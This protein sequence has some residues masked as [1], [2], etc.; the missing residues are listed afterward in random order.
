[1]MSSNE[2][3][4]F[5]SIPNQESDRPLSTYDNLNNGD[6]KTNGSTTA[7][8]PTSENE[9]IERCENANEFPF[10]G[11]SFRFD[12]LK[13]LQQQ[14][15]QQQP[16]TAPIIHTSNGY[17]NVTNNNYKLH[18]SSNGN[19][20][21]NTNNNHHNHTHNDSTHFNGNGVNQMRNSQGHNIVTTIAQNHSS[22]APLSPSPTSSASSSNS[23]S[24]PASS[25]SSTS[26]SLSENNYKQS[27]LQYSNL[28]ENPI[29]N[30]SFSKPV[31]SPAKSQFL[32]LHKP[33]NE[34][35]YATETDG[36]V[37]NGGGGAIKKQ[38]SEKNAL[39]EVD[40][41]SDEEP[42][43]N[44]YGNN[45]IRVMANGSSTT[46]QYQN[47]PSNSSCYGQNQIDNANECTCTCKSSDSAN[48]IQQYESDRYKCNG[49]LTTQLQQQQQQR[50]LANAPISIIPIATMNVP[51]CSKTVDLSSCTTSMKPAKS[52][53][54]DTSPSF[55]M[56]Q[57]SLSQVKTTFIICCSVL[58]ELINCFCWFACFR[59]ENSYVELICLIRWVNCNWSFDTFS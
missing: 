15:Q 59:S 30:R 12:E 43:L 36:K 16:N 20:N 44:N 58:V 38:N 41:I 29:A 14:Q 42:L 10:T 11:I 9:C 24:S 55:R 47:V 26:S 50:N 13:Q 35:E 53:P 48:E 19:G 46:S 52:T 34:I 54:L 8:P 32:G 22:S 2:K 5:R 28:A 6:T 31:H 18:R 39:D 57:S 51:S 7:I 33:S 17:D 4:K 21:S 45:R 49:C 37:T 3:V 23:S 27:S 40:A 25:S 56:N 1:M